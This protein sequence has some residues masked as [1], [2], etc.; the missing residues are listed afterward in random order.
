M[1]EPAVD[2]DVV[3]HNIDDDSENSDGEVLDQSVN[4]DVDDL[5]DEDRTLPFEEGEE[6]GE[7]EWNPDHSDE[8][9]QPVETD[10][11]PVQSSESDSE[12]E[13]VRRST[14]VR[15]A[16]QKFTYDEVGEPSYQ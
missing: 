5:G 6:L 15:S 4:D 2:E 13:T 14:R 11:S 7:I 10:S 3:A 16:P 1:E 9:F 12:E 8:D